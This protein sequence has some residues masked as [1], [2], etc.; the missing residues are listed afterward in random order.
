[1]HFKKNILLIFLL[2]LCVSGKAQY[3]IKADTIQTTYTSS[4]DTLTHNRAIFLSA[5][6]YSEHIG[7]FCKKELQLQKAVKFPV[8]IRL[9]SVDECDRMEGKKHYINTSSF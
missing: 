8:K 2:V 1:M 3:K 6:Y 7:F 5:N 9:G 4:C